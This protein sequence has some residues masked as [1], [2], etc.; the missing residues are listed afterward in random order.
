M[1]AKC[2]HTSNAL[3]S[4][5][6]AQCKR[7]AKPLPNQCE[8]NA[9]GGVFLSKHPNINPSAGDSNRNPSYVEGVN[10]NQSVE[11]FDRNPSA[12]DFT[13]NPSCGGVQ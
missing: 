11:S 1:L 6:P 13:M 9:N 5:M 12:E 8:C 7:D 10:R 3:P 4:A 2:R